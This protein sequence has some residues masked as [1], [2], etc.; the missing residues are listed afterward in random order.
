MNSDVTADAVSQ[1]TSRQQ[2]VL[3]RLTRHQAIKTIA[4][5]MGVSET[6]INQ[7]IRA[8]KDRL[9]VNHKEDLVAL[10]LEAGG[11]P[12]SNSIYRK[13]QLPEV[14]NSAHE[15][16][17]ADT[18][19]FTFQD[20]GAMR[21]APWEAAAYRRVGPGFLDGRGEGAKRMVYIILVAIG[22]PLAV[23][24]TLSAMIALT[25]MLRSSL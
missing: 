18:A 5:E 22:L 14:E 25:E 7:H 17:G 24:F 20:A 1:L 3:D 16:S 6:R 8:I 2:E 13:R 21:R 23:I 11:S 4:D 10:W 9:G 15:Q 19:L 12:F